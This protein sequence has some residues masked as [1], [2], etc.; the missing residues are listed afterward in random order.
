MTAIRALQKED[1]SKLAE[2]FKNLSAVS[3]RMMNRFGE[4]L[5]EEKSVEIARE[6]V[7]KDER[8]E[9]GFVA[10]AEGQITGYGFLRFF[11]GKP[12]KKTTCS[13]GVIVSDDFQGQGLGMKLMDA[14]IEKAKALGMK[15]IWL[16]T[17]TSN[18][19]ALGLYRKLGFQLEGVFMAD[20]F[21]E[22]KPFHT[23]S[24]ALFLDGSGEAVK[25]ER[26]EIIERL[27]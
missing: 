22:G 25:R 27:S 2:F 21:F 1:Q 9:L 20:E 10:E 18:D 24:M 13:L 26:Q 5:D 16:G 6:Q 3:L 19:K 8:E 12:Q 7:E 14:M 15:K 17:Y 4:D 23:V 11:P